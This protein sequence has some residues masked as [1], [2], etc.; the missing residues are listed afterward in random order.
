MKFIFLFEKKKGL[1]PGPSKAPYAVS[2]RAICWYILLLHDL[3]CVQRLKLLQL[4]NK[5]LH[6]IVKNQNIR[7]TTNIN[8]LYFLLLFKRKC[9]PLPPQ[10]PT[11]TLLV[12]LFEC[13]SHLYLQTKSTSE[14]NSLTSMR[15]VTE[16]QLKHTMIVNSYP[17]SA[18]IFWRATEDDPNITYT[19]V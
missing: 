18:S 1:F 5:W 6:P 15:Y 11:P 12:F 14:V 2:W 17:I 9:L 8:E 7:T 4:N 16:I 3:M 10:E 13:F 19:T